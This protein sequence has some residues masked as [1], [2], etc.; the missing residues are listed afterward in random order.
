MSDDATNYLAGNEVNNFKELNEAARRRN[1]ERQKHKPGNQEQGEK[2]GKEG[3]KESSKTD[4][5]D[6]KEGSETLNPRNNNNNDDNDIEDPIINNGT[7]N[8]QSQSNQLISLTALLT[9]YLLIQSQQNPNY[10]K[11]AEQL[12]NTLSNLLSK[13]KQDTIKQEDF[14]KI[15]K[16]NKSFKTDFNKLDTISSNNVVRGAKEIKKMSSE[17]KKSLYDSLKSTKAGTALHSVAKRV[18]NNINE[19]KDYIKVKDSIKS[20]FIGKKISSLKNNIK[21]SLN[22]AKD[23]IKEG[24]N[25]AKDAVNSVARDTKKELSDA[26]NKIANK[27]DKGIDKVVTT[28]DQGVGKV[29]TTIDQG[30]DQACNSVIT[31]SE[32]SK[33]SKPE[34]IINEEAKMSF[35]KSEK[36]PTFDKYKKSE[37]YKKHKED[38]LNNPDKL[39]GVADNLKNNIDKNPNNLSEK[40]I[41]EIKKTVDQ[42]VDKHEAS[43]ENIK[44]VD[45]AVDE[46]KASK[47]KDINGEPPKY[48]EYKEQSS[49]VNHK[50]DGLPT[51]KGYTEANNPAAYQAKDPYPEM[52]EVPGP[53]TT[54]QFQGGNHSPKTGD[55]T[56]GDPVKQSHAE[57]G[58]KTKQNIN[59]QEVKNG[60]APPPP[61]QGPAQQ[62]EQQPKQ[63]FA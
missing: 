17:N 37:E 5:P 15:L 55:Q 21:N 27:V 38:C 26:T 31:S 47:G 29:V 3:K 10:Q 62:K 54:Q 13:T 24:W 45:K 1:E 44:N 12:L 42:T 20:S 53:S 7:S 23:G 50:D 43:K 11:Q 8:Q 56:I 14:D 61:Q 32:K 46:H 25:E 40:E 33:V 36:Y 34:R 58:I 48:E 16:S 28:I 49:A 4:D 30:V 57:K 18:E 9:A 2:E 60:I 51:Y 22:E 41:E 52:K 39:K 59:L 19:K 6:N 63:A 35:E